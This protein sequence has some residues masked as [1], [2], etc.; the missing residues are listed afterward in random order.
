MCRLTTIQG[1]FIQFR[2][3]PIPFS[4]T[5]AETEGV[6]KNQ[7]LIAS[8]GI[9]QFRT[10]EQKLS[11][12]GNVYII[13]GIVGYTQIIDLLCKSANHVRVPR[14]DQKNLWS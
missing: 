14:G 1:S 5:E 10:E 8:G 9:K 7:K 12:F 6:V 2:G 4:Y 3:V 13:H 11:I